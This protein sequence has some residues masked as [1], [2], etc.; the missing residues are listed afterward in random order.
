MYLCGQRVL[1]NLWRTQIS[2]RRMIWLPPN[3]LPPF[4]RKKILSLFQP[5]CVSPVELTD[6]RGG[7]VWGGAKSYNDEKAWLSISHSIL[8]ILSNFS[9]F[10]NSSLNHNT[11]L[12]VLD[13]DWGWENRKID[14]L[15]FSAPAVLLCF[16]RANLLLCTFSTPIPC[17][18]VSDIH[19]PTIP[20]LSHD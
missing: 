17:S 15:F 1:N 10:T 14:N 6:E 20:S 4:S 2:R 13:S 18:P 19:A 9:Y 16:S 3:P 5:F 8:S 12:T 7:R 11:T